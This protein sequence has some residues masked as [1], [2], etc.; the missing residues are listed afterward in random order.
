MGQALTKV[1][2][3][4]KMEAPG[5][6]EAIRAVI[7]RLSME[8]LATPEHHEA[9]RALTYLL[10]HDVAEPTEVQEWGAEAFNI[11][12][13]NAVA[14]TG[15][16]LEERKQARAIVYPGSFLIHYITPKV[17]AE[18]PLRPQGNTFVLQF[19][20]SEVTIPA[21]W[22]FSRLRGQRHRDNLGGQDLLDMRQKHT[23]LLDAMA[24]HFGWDPSMKTAIQDDLSHYNPWQSISRAR[25]YRNIMYD[26]SHDPAFFYDVVIVY[27]ETFGHVPKQVKAHLERE[28]LL[29]YLYERPFHPDLSSGGSSHPMRDLPISPSGITSRNEPPAPRVNDSKIASDLRYY[30]AHNCL[31]DHARVGAAVRREEQNI[32]AGPVPEDPL[33]ELPV[34]DVPGHPRH[35]TPVQAGDRDFGN[36]LQQLHNL[37]P[38][39]LHRVRHGRIERARNVGRT[40]YELPGM[41][42]ALGVGVGAYICLRLGLW[43][44]TIMD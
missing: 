30:R 31:P 12:G 34:P 2:N 14:I 28:N 37:E 29:W 21:D 7:V 25:A 44:N 41:P 13:L 20:G 32:V 6:V 10:K 9:L 17:W 36:S 23:E 38:V 8:P 4:F 3:H 22:Q 5:Q 16:F 24:A 15:L 39:P 40:L 27:I 35:A 1:P 18:Q 26:R 42:F 19:G 43:G 33:P 11:S